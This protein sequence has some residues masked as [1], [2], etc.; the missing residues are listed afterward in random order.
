MSESFYK[1]YKHWHYQQDLIWTLT[2]AFV[3]GCGKSGTTWLMN[4]LNGHDEIVIRGEGCFTYQLVPALQQAMQHF[5]GHQKQYDKSACTHLQSIDQ[6]LIA[7]TAIDSLFAHY[8]QE[9]KQ[10]VMQLRVIGDKTPQHAVTLEPLSQIYPEGRFIHIVR[11]P[12]DVATSAWFHQGVG[13][14][15][16]FEEFIPYFMNTVW[17]LHVGNAKKVA[18]KLGDRYLEV[19]Y[20]DL[21]DHEREQV[22]RILNHLGANASEAAVRKCM[23]HGSFQKNSGG[24]E[25]GDERSD[26][27]L[28]KGVTGDWVNHIPYDLA[29]RCCDKIADLMEAFGYNPTCR[30]SRTS[31]TV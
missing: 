8:L 14:E 27:F 21:H 1:L 2:K 22:Q 25:R 10:D 7:R 30:Q 28:R 3:L 11:D 4:L 13:G 15:R 18:T 19:R 5:N 6:L 20:E 26:Q 12:R 17:P 24:R 31:M 16:S 29:Q 9:S 23:D